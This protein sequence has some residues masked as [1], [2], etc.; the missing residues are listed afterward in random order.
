MLIFHIQVIKHF[1]HLH[2]SV[3]VFPLCLRFDHI[4][5]H[6]SH[7]PIPGAATA[8]HPSLRVL[9][10]ALRHEAEPVEEG[11]GGGHVLAVGGAALT[12][13]QRNTHSQT[14]RVSQTYLLLTDKS[15]D[16]AGEPGE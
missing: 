3:I 1:S 13:R 14:S 10:L 15:P 6:P 9:L 7:P 11:V 5:S 2:L 8:P 4:R 16:E 12:L